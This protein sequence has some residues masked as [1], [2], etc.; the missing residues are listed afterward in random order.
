MSESPHRPTLDQVVNGYRWDGTRWV[1]IPDAVVEGYRWDGAQWV[2]IPDAVEN[3]YHWDGTRWVPIPD[4]VED[5]NRGDVVQG[6]APGTEGPPEQLR[7][8]PQSPWWRPWVW[9]VALVVLVAAAGL[10]ALR[11]AGT[12]VT[13]GPGSAS[14]GPT[15]CATA[16]P[17]ASD[18]ATITLEAGLEDVA[19]DPTTHLVY[20]AGS[21]SESGE[22]SVTV[23]DTTTATVTDRIGFSNEQPTALALDPSTSTLFVGHPGGSISVVDIGTLAQGTAIP[24]ART[25]GL[26]MDPSTRTLYAAH[27]FTDNLSVIDA[28]TRT[29]T[30]TIEVGDQPVGVAVDPSAHRLYVANSWARGEDYSLSV[31]DTTTLQV[32]DSIRVG[33]QP[34]VLA[35][36]ELTHTLY[37]TGASNGRVCALDP[38][39][40][41]ELRSWTIG[42]Q[43]YGVAVD[44]GSRTLF[45]ADY[46][47]TL[48]M[49]PLD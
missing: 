21:T 41:R 23:M 9:V 16:G 1:P 29:V 45:V 20:V 7:S 2:P 46:G 33:S 44:P 18:I 3:G 12:S 4:A 26:A 47:G 25:G 10:G 5:R 13:V 39:T 32:I 49:I 15:A 8:G 36:D 42:G 34:W 30:G 38:E 43:L 31:V 19:V 17:P 11:L 27:Y 48:S 6:L 22:Y 35:V 40:H 37:V 24:V 14:T 28:A